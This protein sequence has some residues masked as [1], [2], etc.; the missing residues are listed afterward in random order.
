MKR[1]SSRTLAVLAVILLIAAAVLFWRQ[2]APTTTLTAGPAPVPVTVAAVEARDVPHLARALG[3]VQ[4]VHS[5]T[6]RSQVDGV[7]TEVLFEEGQRVAKGDLLARIDDRGIRAALDQ[8]RAERARN[9]AELRSARLDLER[10][11]Q[12]VERNAV[13]RQEYDRQ[14]ALVAQLEASA[15]ASAAAVA[16]AEVELSHTRIVSPVTGRAGFRRVDPG[17]YVR[18]SDAEGLF[19]VTQIEP[20]DVIFSLSES[21]LPRLRGLAGE[22]ATVRVYDRAGGS[23]LGEGTLTTIDNQIN[24]ATGTIRLRARLPNTSGELWPGQS[25]VVQLR[26]GVSADALVVPVAAV[27]HGLSGRYVLRVSEGRAEPVAVT[28]A[29]EDDSIAVISEG[30]AAGD[31][32]ITDGHSRVRTGSKVEPVAATEPGR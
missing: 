19:S 12:L 2:R 9:E 1:S 30:V 21:E 15:A 18:A 29:F 32:V 25:V 11:A 8:A 10:Y 31:S 24:R 5:V 4:S 13:S 27:R 3:N 7:L 16:A 17:N 22:A 26:T 6:L 14:R 28:V 23:L 20:I